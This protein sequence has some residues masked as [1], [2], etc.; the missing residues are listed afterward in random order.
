[1]NDWRTHPHRRY[2]PLLDRW[3][4]VSPHRLARPWQGEV[5][6]A[7]PADRPQFDPDC[8]L[9][10]GNVRAGGKRNPAYEETY[11]FENDFAAL[12]PYVPESEVHDGLMLARSE[13]GRCRVL[14]FS[15]RHDLD[16]ARMSVPAIRRVVDAW[17]ALYDELGALPYVTAVTAFENRGAAMGA[18]NPHPHGQVWANESIPVDMAR[19]DRAQHD[20][21]LKNDAC[22]LCT[23][24]RNEL[25]AGERIVYENAH[26]C[27][28][29]PFWAVWPFEA[30]VLPRAHA[31]NL[32]DLG[33]AQRDGLAQAIQELT[34]R[35]DRLFSTPFP[36]SMGFHQQPCDGVPHD[37]WHAHAH[38]F[39]PLLRSATVRK[40]MVGY[41]MLAQPQRDVTAEEAAERLRNA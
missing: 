28:L 38:Y 40:Y 35:Y 15:P 36:Y 3:V 23:Y 22:L 20:Y 24:V 27:V 9:C 34:S 41:E 17:A 31:G 21:Y 14:C 1:M 16:V 25:A 11:V 30:L 7:P 33:G 5:T 26:A 37:A 12:L 29:V 2:D 4:L 10:P 13:R 39:P 18:S 32:V 8:Y 19:E 6:G